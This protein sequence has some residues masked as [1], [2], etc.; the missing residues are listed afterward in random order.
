[1]TY[2]LGN[3]DGLPIS[4]RTENR[5]DKRIL[6]WRPRL[7]KRSLGRP[8]ARLSDDLRR[9]VGRIWMRLAE[10]RVRS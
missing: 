4:A 10:D 5:W 3:M 8:Q 9:T 7:G 2:I 6:E 1:M